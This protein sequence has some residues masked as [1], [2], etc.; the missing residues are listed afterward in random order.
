MPWN[1]T[2]SAGINNLTDEDPRFYAGGDYES[3]IYDIID[4]SYWVSFT[5][6]F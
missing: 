6:A 5:Q 2:I 4:R 1:N 3:S